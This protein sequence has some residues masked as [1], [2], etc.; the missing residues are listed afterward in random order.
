MEENA[1]T[2]PTLNQPLR[3]KMLTILCILTFIGS[4]MN[5][6]SS[7]TISVFHETFVTLGAVVAERFELPGI[8]MILNADPAFFWLS[9]IFYILSFTGAWMMWTLKKAGFHIY[10]I[11]QIL[12]ILAPMYFFQLHGPALPDI[13]L[14]GTFIIL[15][16]THLKQMS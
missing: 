8:E 13:I 16:S 14:S 10:T 4:G 12:L 9:T 11:S 3:P 6:F 5:F 7:F 2:D 15:Y 1:V